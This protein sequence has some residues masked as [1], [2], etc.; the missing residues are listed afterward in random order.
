MIET[1][2][3]LRGYDPKRIAK[4]GARFGVTLEELADN[5][6][7]QLA[8]KKI[9]DDSRVITNLQELLGRKRRDI[10]SSRF[11][12]P[13]TPAQSVAVRFHLS[14]EFL[15][16]PKISKLCDYK[17]RLDEQAVQVASPEERKAV[18]RIRPTTEQTSR[19]VKKIAALYGF[20][21]SEKR[22]DV[23]IS[24]IAHTLLFTAR[25]RKIRGQQTIEGELLNEKNVSSS[26]N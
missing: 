15:S 14:D 5:E 7:L 8:I 3:I 4:L 9:L 25:L 10:S 20:N 11:P 22:P 12:C 18:G 26:G 13:L 1:K 23:L 21:D 17:A 6:P 24:S 19:L 16:D 2:P